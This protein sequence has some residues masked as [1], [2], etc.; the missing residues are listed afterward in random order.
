MDQSGGQQPRIVEL[1]HDGG[2]RGREGLF[3]RVEA[4]RF[5]SRSSGRMLISTLPMGRVTV[6]SVQS[7]GHDIVLVEPSRATLLAPLAGSLAVDTGNLGLSAGAGGCLLVRTG[8]RKTSVRPPDSQGMFRAAVVLVPQRRYAPAHR[9]RPGLAVGSAEANATASA[10]RDHLTYL[11][12][13]HANPASPLLRPA[14][15]RASE[16][17]VLDLAAALDELDQPPDL[18]ERPASEAHVRRA[19][20]IMR[21]CSDD[22]LSIEDLAQELG[23]GMRALQLA[24]RLRRGI[25]PRTA[26]TALRLERARERLL[27]PTPGAS[28]TEAALASGFTHFGRFAQSYRARFGEAPSETLRRAR[29]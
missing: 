29:Q 14:A 5:T 9:R 11:L 7:V 22:P 4:F 23:I 10:L 12:R 19:E 16:A 13:E 1:T 27:Q 20:E 25:S 3:G 26:L 6:A 21:A 17:L 28:V 18:G 24:F 2:Y 8:Y 15:L